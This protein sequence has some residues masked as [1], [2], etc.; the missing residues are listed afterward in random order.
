M[1][2]FP[3]I[4]R[5][6]HLQVLCSVFFTVSFWNLAY[7]SEVVAVAGIALCPIVNAIQL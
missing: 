4:F 6:I 5:P 2:L 3:S 1:F 7:S